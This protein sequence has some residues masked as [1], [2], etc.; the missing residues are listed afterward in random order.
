MTPTSR[1]Q[2]ARPQVRRIVATLKHVEHKVVAAVVGT[3]ARIR[4]VPLA[5]VGWNPHLVGISVVQAIAAFVVLLPPVVLRIEEIRI[6]IE[7]FPIVDAG[8]PSPRTGRMPWGHLGSASEI[9]L[10]RGSQTY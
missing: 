3:A 5:V 9:E 1:A 6:V 10:Q 2:R 4:I 8:R 7:A